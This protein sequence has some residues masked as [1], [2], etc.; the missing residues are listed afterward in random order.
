M[1]I[2]PNT[3]GRLKCQRLLISFPSSSS[4]QS[5]TYQSPFSHKNCSFVKNHPNSCWRAFSV[6][7]YISV[8]NRRWNKSNGAILCL[9]SRKRTTISRVEDIKDCENTETEMF[10]NMG[11]RLKMT[12]LLKP[13]LLG[14]LNHTI[15]RNLF[16]NL[17]PCKW[18]KKGHFPP[19]WTFSSW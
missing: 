2:G 8:I 13:E 9:L 5:Q 3:H 6:Q 14:F 7:R 11:K 16:I 15:A 12:S 4:S 18:C 19:P 1:A 17:H 10:P